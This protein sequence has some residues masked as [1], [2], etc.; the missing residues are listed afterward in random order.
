MGREF[1]RVVEAEKGRE[2]ESREVEASH[3]HIERGEKGMEREGERKDRR[4]ERQES[5]RRGQAAP[6]IVGQAYLTV[7]R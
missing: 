3:D 5:E 4:Q 1:K 6:F 7:T 2:G